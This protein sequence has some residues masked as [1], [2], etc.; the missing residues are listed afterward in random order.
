MIVISDSV[1]P[2]VAMASAPKR[3]TKKTSATAKTDSI[4]ISRTIGTASNTTALPMGASV[5]SCVEPRTASLNVSQT[6]GG[7]RTETADC[8][9]GI[10]TVYV[11]LIPT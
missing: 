1:I 8:S 10:Q 11:S 5:R 3:P 9:M 2:T 6:P 4:T 7:G